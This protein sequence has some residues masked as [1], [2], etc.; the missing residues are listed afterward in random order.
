MEHQLLL[1]SFYSITALIFSIFVIFMYSEKEKFKNH[2]NTVFL[3]I[4][5]FTSVISIAEIFY[6]Y[7][8]SKFETT[9]IIV[10][11]SIRLFILLSI[12]WKSL[13]FY[14]VYCQMSRKYDEEKKKQKRKTALMIFSIIGIILSVVSLL[15]PIKYYDY[16]THLYRFYGNTL[17]LLMTQGLVLIAFT[18]YGIFFGN[19]ELKVRDKIPLIMAIIFVIALLV[20]KYTVEWAEYNTQSFQFALIAIALFFSLENQ[21]SKALLELKKSK[22]EADYDLLPF[23]INLDNSVR[24]RI[25]DKSITIIYNVD[26]TLPKKVFG[27]EEKLSKCFYDAFLYFINNL[28]TG[29]INFKMEPYKN[30]NLFMFHVTYNVYVDV[31]SE[32]QKEFVDDIKNIENNDINGRIISLITSKRY[33]DM[34]GGELEVKIEDN[35]LTIDIYVPEKIVDSNPV[36]EVFSK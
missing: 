28:D 9:N 30:G 4:L 19:K 33:I 15:L 29:A 10:P 34:F 36:G 11:L 7:C 26:E 17:Y 22:D 1:S 20:V 35:I 6:A 24:P 16:S 23:L 27:D 18:C 14:Y 13:A 21:D 8:L 5:I 25:G 12:A 3:I 32:K 31:T 2:E